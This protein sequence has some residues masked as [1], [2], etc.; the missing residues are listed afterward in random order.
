MEAKFTTQAE[1]NS[2]NMPNCLVF[3]LHMEEQDRLKC[4]LFS[5]FRDFID[6]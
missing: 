4:H 1:H 5:L 3:L 2:Q 6:L